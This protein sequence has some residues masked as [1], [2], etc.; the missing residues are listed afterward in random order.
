MVAK[1]A[2]RIAAVVGSS[3]H[4]LQRSRQMAIAYMLAL[5]ASHLKLLHKEWCILEGRGLHLWEGQATH[6]T[7]ASPKPAA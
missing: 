1:V 2:V 7:A 3:E 4:G 6:S 5:H